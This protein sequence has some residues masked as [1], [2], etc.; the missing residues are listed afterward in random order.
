MSVPSSPATVWYTSKIKQYC[1]HDLWTGWITGGEVTV[2]QRQ[3]YLYI[4]TKK[5][6][7]H[8]TFPVYGSIV[9]ANATPQHLEHQ[10]I[11]WNCSHHCRYWQCELPIILLSRNAITFQTP[12]SQNVCARPIYT[13]G[14]LLHAGAIFS[15]LT[16][17]F[18]TVI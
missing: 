12:S 5:V 10:Q 7:L 4:G 14:K 9:V 18:P 1:L 3:N 6:D 16:I 17:N 2:P 13:T 15:G 11:C 8:A